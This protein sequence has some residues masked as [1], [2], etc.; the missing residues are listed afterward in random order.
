MQENAEPTMG[1]LSRHRNDF[2]GRLSAV[3]INHQ[4]H[5][6]SRL[7]TQIRF[8][9]PSLFELATVSGNDAV[10]GLESGLAGRAIGFD[11]NHAH[12]LLADCGSPEL[13]SDGVFVCR[14]LRL[15]TA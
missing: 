5:G 15:L 11:G 4:R 12:S 10:I 7:S 13:G 2:D 9:M 3:A 6:T 14:L 1:T 8:Q